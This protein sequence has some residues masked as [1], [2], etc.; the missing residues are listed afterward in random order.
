MSAFTLSKVHKSQIRAG[1]TISHN[2]KLM[3]VG[4]SDLTL[5]DFFGIKIFGDS[6][7]IGYQPVLRAAYNDPITAS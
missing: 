2:G 6:Y 1:D 7:K 3:T 5:C 4:M